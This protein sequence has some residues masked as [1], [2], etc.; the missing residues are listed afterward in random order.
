MEIPAELQGTILLVV[1]AVGGFLVFKMKQYKDRANKA[2]ARADAIT[3]AVDR[4]LQDGVINEAEMKN[5]IVTAKQMGGW[6]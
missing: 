1:N 2:D 3:D 5:I 4:A 6:K